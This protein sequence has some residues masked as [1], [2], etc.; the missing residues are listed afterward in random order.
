MAEPAARGMFGEK[1][2]NRLQAGAEPMLDPGK[3]LVIADLQ[4]VREVV[5]NTRYDQRVRVGH[6][7]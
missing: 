6:V 2:L 3:F 1:R 5:S 4:H 7:D